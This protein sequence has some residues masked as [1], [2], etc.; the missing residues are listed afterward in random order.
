M[1]MARDKTKDS[2]DRYS[3]RVGWSEEDEC[4]IATCLEFPSLSGHGDSYEEALK[5]IVAVV[6]ESVAWM[7]EDKEEI[8]EPYSVRVFKGNIPLR[9]P[10]ETHR[11]IAILASE[12]RV[13]LNQFITSL[14]ES[15][16]EI[17]H[18]SRKLAQVEKE[19]IALRSSM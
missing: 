2:V 9:I 18:L 3:Y 16:C 12:S 10:P 17:G 14:I 11:R 15:T 1:K 4:Y 13:S 5:D 7:S 19:I 8:P 6:K